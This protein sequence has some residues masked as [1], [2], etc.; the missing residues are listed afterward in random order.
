MT[1]RTDLPTTEK[2]TIRLDG[3]EVE[4][5]PS[6]RACIGISRLHESMY[7]VA[8]KIMSGNFDTIAAVTAFA[9]GVANNEKLQEKIY[10]SGVLDIRA[11][12]IRFVSCVN[13]GGRIPDSEE[14]DTPE[15][16][17]TPSQT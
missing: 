11:P 16:P 3:E 7:A 13:N 10:Q 15:N 4:L 17:Q 8:D 6:L 14:D 12:L 5:E 1:K 9:L 2:I